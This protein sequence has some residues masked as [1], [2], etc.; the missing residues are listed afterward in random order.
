MRSHLMSADMF[1]EPAEPQ[2]GHL[3]S[4]SIQLFYTILIR[5]TTN[6]AS[7]SCKRKAP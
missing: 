2:T 4:Y 3:L 1:V 6:F 5:S 7:K